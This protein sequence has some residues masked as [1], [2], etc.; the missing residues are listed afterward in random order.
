ML[1]ALHI[2]DFAIVEAL[3]LELGPGMTVLT[4]ET[5]AGKSILV[6]ALGL[7]LGGR[8][9]SA[10]VRSGRERA[11][12]AAGFDI[13]DCAA[14]SAWLEDRDLEHDGECWLRRVVAGAGRS[15]CYIN[16]RPVP[17]Q[18][19]RELG[20]LLVDVHGQHA[21]QS[22]LRR[23]AQRQVLD[24]F[25]GDAAPV[26]EV[27]QGFRRL[28]ALQR[29][30][31]ALHRAAEDRQARLELLRYQVRELEALDLQADEIPALER[32]RE[33]AANA[34]RLMEAASEALDLVYAGEQGAALDRLNKGLA[35]LEPLRRLDP[36]LDNAVTLLDSAAIQVQ[37]A[38][39]ELRGYAGE[40]E[41]D[42][43]RLEW[44]EQRLDAIIQVARKHRVSGEELPALG[45][46]LAEE[47]GVLEHADEQLG[48]LE[49]RLQQARQAYLESAARLSSAR[50][51]AGRR[52]GEE[53]AANLQRLGMP[54]GRFE[55][56]LEAGD[57]RPSASGLERVTFRVAANPGQPPRPLSKVASGGE[58]SRI[59]LAIQVLVARR[60]RVP[61][62]VF[63]EVDV[64][65]GGGVAEIVGRLLRRLGKSRQVLCVTHL[66]QVAAQGHRH[67]RVEKRSAG[68]STQTRIRPLSDAERVGEIARM[69]GGVKITGQT[70]AHAREMIEHAQRG[71]Q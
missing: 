13:G 2:R 50:V 12:T 36:R 57:G 8:A 44:L 14:A 29:E 6:D 51:E 32:E 20:E 49:G 43:A 48:E 59:A 56:L 40:L 58:L 37:E 35:V 26:E 3:E 45:K 28:A 66:P 11:E 30:Y 34:A 60:L 18:Q 27:A 62:L 16:G 31:D 52:L 53:V 1:T 38:A 63:D 21:H 71:R 33:V 69:L 39:A 15:R 67:L 64:G 4:G 22:L 9:D 41:L 70:R 54:A 55:V 47:L 7:A 25:A 5:G 42:P 23:D 10:V 17:V 19:L 61:T 24:D 46:T 68:G 65:I